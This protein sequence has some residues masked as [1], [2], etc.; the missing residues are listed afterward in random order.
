MTL[1]MRDKQKYNEGLSKGIS[2]G[3]SIGREE[4]INEGQDFLFSA[5]NAV[6]KGATED[7]LRRQGF[8]DKTIQ[9]ALEA[10]ASK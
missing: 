1:L 10:L 4:G 5:I 3:I 8:S 7:D 2:E 6:R 9:Y